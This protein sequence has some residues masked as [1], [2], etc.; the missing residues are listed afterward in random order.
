MIGIKRIKNLLKRKE[1]KKK[2]GLTEC[3]DHKGVK[4]YNFVNPLELP[5]FRYLKVMA[6]INQSALKAQVSDVI[7]YTELIDDFA[8]NKDHESILKYSQYLRAF[9]DLEYTNTLLFNIAEP[10]ILLEGENPD[11]ESNEWSRNKKRMFDDYDHFKAFFL[12]MGFSYLLSFQN[13]SIGHTRI[14]DYLK[15]D[16]VKKTEEVFLKLI[17]GNISK[18]S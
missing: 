11:D 17:A 9:V 14:E 6:A 2:Y 7:A 16:A 12:R 3:Y 1:D 13:Q 8:R 4:C 18:S 5:Y 10:L 15:K